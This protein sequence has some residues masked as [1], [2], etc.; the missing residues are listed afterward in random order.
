M[1]NHFLTLTVALSILL[2]T[3]DE[4]RTHYLQ[5][6]RDLMTYFV[7]RCEKIYGNT[8]TVYNVHSLIH[9]ADDVETFG[10]SLNEVSC[11]PFENHLQKLKRMVKTGKNPIAQVAK[12][13]KGLENSRNVLPRKERSVIVSTN[14]RDSC[15]RLGSDKFAFVK[16]KRQSGRFLCDVVSQVDMDNLFQQPCCSKLLNIVRMNNGNAATTRRKRVLIE[17]EELGRKVAYLP[18]KDGFVL[19]PLLHDNERQ[20]HV[21]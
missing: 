4:K 6:A 16:E 7:Q 10:C 14:M 9:I 17:S 5:Y 21:I 1:H 18:Y 2:D 11:F 12:R 15:F 8:F 3:D 20:R 19:M 13:L